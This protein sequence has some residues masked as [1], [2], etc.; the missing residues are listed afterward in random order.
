MVL[1]L[2]LTGVFFKSELTLHVGMTSCV[3]LGLNFVCLEL[4]L[5]IVHSIKTYICE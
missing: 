3:S 2:A 1:S 4:K 5:E